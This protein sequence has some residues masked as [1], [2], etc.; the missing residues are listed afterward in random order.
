M[1]RPTETARNPRASPGGS[2]PAGDNPAV[3]NLEAR[4]PAALSRPDKRPTAQKSC[5]G[6]YRPDHNL[7]AAFRPDR[8]FAAPKSRR[9]SDRSDHTRAWKT[10]ERCRKASSLAPEC[11]APRCTSAVGKQTNPRTCLMNCRRET[12]RGR[13]SPSPGGQDRNRANPA[14]WN[15]WLTLPARRDHSRRESETL[16]RTNRRASCRASSRAWHCQ[17]RLGQRQNRRRRRNPTERQSRDRH[18]RKQGR[19]A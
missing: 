14:Y 16:R 1:V 11:P 18:Q 8:R 7:G 3:R 4:N 10:T 6:S 5:R 12:C 2:N 9:A 13:W 19:V 17:P 15:P